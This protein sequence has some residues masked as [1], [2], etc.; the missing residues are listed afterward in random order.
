MC[1][2]FDDIDHFGVNLSGAAADDCETFADGQSADVATVTIQRHRDTSRSA[3][4]FHRNVRASAVAYLTDE[5]RLTWIAFRLQKD[6]L[7]FIDTFSGGDDGAV[8]ASEDECGL[9]CFTYEYFG[10]GGAR[11]FIVAPLSDF[12]L[13]Y[14][15]MSSTSRHYYELIMERRPTRLYL[16]VECAGDGDDIAAR[17]RHRNIVDAMINTLCRCVQQAFAIEVCDADLMILDSTN[18]QKISV[19]LV[20]NNKLCFHDATHGT[21]T[22]ADGL[23]TTYSRSSWTDSSFMFVC[24]KLAALCLGIALV[25]CVNRRILLPPRH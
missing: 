2:E 16:D 1:A 6:A 17:S 5:Y 7:A 15:V 23:R 10:G 25:Y 20:A 11:H 24:V 21:K 22:R 4:R 14:D 3:L 8:D 13:K 9:R 18:A 12:W 19:H